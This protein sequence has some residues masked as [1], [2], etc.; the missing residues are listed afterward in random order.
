MI[1]DHTVEPAVKAARPLLIYCPSM[2]S[3]VCENFARI[4]A[5]SSPSR[6]FSRKHFRENFCRKCRSMFDKR[7]NS[8]A[9]K[10]AK[11]SRKFSQQLSTRENFRESVFAER[12]REKNCRQ[13]LVYTFPMREGRACLIHRG[14]V[15]ES[16]PCIFS[17]SR[18]G[19]SQ[20]E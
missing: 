17:E 9:N 18:R 1:P 16:A 7:E 2:C 3:G 11:I 14:G 13:M 6:Q 4:F 12:F 15:R 8:C 19:R 5:A 10:F 20:S